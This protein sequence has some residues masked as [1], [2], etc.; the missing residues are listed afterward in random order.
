MSKNRT[1][2]KEYKKDKNGEK[3]KIETITILVAEEGTNLE[4]AKKKLN[5]YKGISGE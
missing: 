5:K 4:R 3:D 1:V 2:E